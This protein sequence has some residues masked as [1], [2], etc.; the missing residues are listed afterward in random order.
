MLLAAGT[1]MD[2]PFG[3]LDDGIMKTEDGKST[4]LFTAHAYSILQVR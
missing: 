3:T 4:G 1:Y 2:G